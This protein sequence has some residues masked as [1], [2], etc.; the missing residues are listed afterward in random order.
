MLTVTTGVAVSMKL[1]GTVIGKFCGKDQLS[2]R[3]EEMVLIICLFILF[4]N[5]RMFL[6]LLKQ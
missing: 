1:T 3:R 6:N 4:L 2:L 5:N